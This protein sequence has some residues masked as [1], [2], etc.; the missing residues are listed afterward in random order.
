MCFL[1]NIYWRVLRFI[2]GRKPE[3]DVDI[4]PYDYDL[5]P[6]QEENENEEESSSSG[7]SAPPIPSPFQPPPILPRPRRFN[8]YNDY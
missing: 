4:T 8:P 7:S 2:Y 5:L 3:Y 1:R 6:M